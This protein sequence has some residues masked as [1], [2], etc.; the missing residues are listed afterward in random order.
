MSVVGSSSYGVHIAVTSTAGSTNTVGVTSTGDIFGWH[1]AVLQT[2]VPE[3]AASALVL[4]GLLG[5]IV[6]AQRITEG[7]RGTRPRWGEGIR[8]VRSAAA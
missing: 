6:R 4:L 1:V 7:A 2:P 5:G 8:S 3:P